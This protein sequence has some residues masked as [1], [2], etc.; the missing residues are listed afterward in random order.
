MTPSAVI[1]LMGVGQSPALF[2]IQ[3]TQVNF[4]QIDVIE[5]R[6]GFF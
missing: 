2:N 1:T 4:A 6:D 5:L 3:I